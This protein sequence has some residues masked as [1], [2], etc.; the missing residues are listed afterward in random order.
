MRLSSITIALA[1]LLVSGAASAS[2]GGEKEG[3]KAAGGP[4]GGSESP[5]GG[6]QSDLSDTRDRASD[7]TFSNK[8]W[9]IGAGLEYHH[10]GL[11]GAALNNGVLRNVNYWSLYARWDVTPY[12]RLQLTGGLYQYFLADSGESGARADDLLLKYTRRIPLPGAVTMRV[13][14]SLTA[15]TSYG[16]QLAGLYTVPRLQLQ[17]DRTF[18]KYFTLDARLSGSMYV[19][20]Y[21]E[22]GAAFNNS[23]NSGFG[24]S[25]LGTNG[26]GA[27]ANPKGSYSMSLNAELAM[28]FHTPLA[29][30][31]TAYV[32]YTWFYDVACG[33]NNPQDMHA[34]AFGTNAMGTCANQPT[35]QQAT[36]Q[37]FTQAYADEVYVR[38]TLPSFGGFKSDVAFTWAPNGDVTMGYSSVL[39]GNGVGHVYPFYNRE[40]N[41]IY[42]SLNGRY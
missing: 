36:Q 30:G 27:N 33:G 40:T 8:V 38:Y 21:A 11:D 24:T 18:G 5:G 22:G 12:D 34:G 17:A 1:A 32:G 42:F 6:K 19:V 37:P 28:P 15:P 41:E 7:T 2:G 35:V 26:G 20:K 3:G 4:S 31:L 14:G 29:V 9:E 10:T 16:S 13:S 25:G 39:N 23:G